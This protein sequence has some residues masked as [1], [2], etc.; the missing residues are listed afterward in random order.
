MS[1][2]TLLKQKQIC[3]A[4]IILLGKIGTLSE[5]A[6]A[7][8]SKKWEWTGWMDGYP[9]TV[10]TSRVPAV[11]KISLLFLPKIWEG[12]CWGS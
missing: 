6:D 8:L 4:H 2:F 7:P 12:R 11:L 1:C 3:P 9:K 5:W 10:V